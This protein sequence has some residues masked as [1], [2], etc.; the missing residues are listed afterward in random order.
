[1][2]QS[3]SGKANRFSANQEIPRILWNPKVLHRVYK[4]LPPVPTLSQINPVHPPITLP[5]D[6]L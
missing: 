5:D 1:M 3:P 2:Q 6:P 4:S